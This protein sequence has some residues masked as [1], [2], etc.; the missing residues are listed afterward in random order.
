L[1]KLLPIRKAKGNSHLMENLGK[2]PKKSHDFPMSIT[3]LYSSLLNKGLITPVAPKPVTNLLEGY[4][5]S[6]TCKFHY[7]APRHSTE[8][9]RLLRHKIQSPIDSVALIFDGATQ[10]K[11]VATTT[12]DAQ[13]EEVNAIMREEDDCPDLEDLHGY[14]DSLFVALVD[15]GYICPKEHGDTH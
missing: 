11:V 14:M 6:K 1:A 9:C 10:S 7:D 15:L 4:D 8:E 13:G 3:K 5:P 2:K 12:F